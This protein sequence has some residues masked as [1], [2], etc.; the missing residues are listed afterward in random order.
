MNCKSFE[1]F[2]KEDKFANTKKNIF[3][4]K[5]EKHEDQTPIGHHIQITI[6]E[7]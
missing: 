2:K 7:R 6:R 3:S 1:L 5:Y 4:L